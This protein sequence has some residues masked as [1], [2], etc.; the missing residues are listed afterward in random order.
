MPTDEQCAKQE[1]CLLCRYYTDCD[2]DF[3][4]A[5]EGE[6]ILKGI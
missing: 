5:H 2:R 4:E 6:E 1:S 3:K